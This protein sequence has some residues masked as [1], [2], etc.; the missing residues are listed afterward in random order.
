[1]SLDY[2]SSIV[3]IIYKHTKLLK[4]NSCICENL[5]VHKKI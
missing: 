3:C 1:M 2:G 4:V 5:Q